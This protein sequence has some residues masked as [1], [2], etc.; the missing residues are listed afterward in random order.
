[1]DKATY[2]SLAGKRISFVHDV[3]L[4]TSLGCAGL[5]RVSGQE[6]RRIHRSG[7]RRGGAF[8]VR[9]SGSCVESAALELLQLS[10][11]TV[12]HLQGAAASR[13]ASERHM[14]LPV[15][16]C[17]CDE[18]FTAERLGLP[19]SPGCTPAGFPA[20]PP[21]PPSPSSPP[22]ATPPSSAPRSSVPGASSY[23]S[24]SRERRVKTRPAGEA[25]AWSAASAAHF[26]RMLVRLPL[27][28]PVGVL[29]PE[30]Q[31]LLGQLQ[32]QPGHLQAGLV[33]LGVGVAQTGAQLPQLPAQ[34]LGRALAGLQALLQAPRL[35]QGGLGLHLQ[36]DGSLL[37]NSSAGEEPGGGEAAVTWRVFRFASSRFIWLDVSFSLSFSLED[38]ESWTED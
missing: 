38:K 2:L 28:G 29:L 6:K 37:E 26:C 16:V 8:F 21:V 25:G 11:G 7:R 13:R 32:G 30:E 24:A 36:T 9:R 5:F 34:V 3:R 10:S 31:V 23:R 35:L 20:G 14:T 4:C 19:D 33:Q 12:Q 15:C 18:M 27:Q 22:E 17:V 1:M